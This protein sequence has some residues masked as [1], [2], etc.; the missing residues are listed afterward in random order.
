MTNKP[1]TNE[2]EIIAAIMK[3]HR[4]KK[5]IRASDMYLKMGLPTRQAFYGYESGK[6]PI[7]M[8]IFIKW[9]AALGLRMYSVAI[10]IEEALTGKKRD[11]RSKKEQQIVAARKLI[12]KEEKKDA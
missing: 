11:H 5:K 6:Q 1:K 12:A 9:C 4:I 7:S 3:N 8:A 10:N 2:Y